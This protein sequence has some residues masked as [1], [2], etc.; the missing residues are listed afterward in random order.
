MAQ[1][2]LNAPAIYC[3]HLTQEISPSKTA[4]SDLPN[5]KQGTG[6]RPER[7]PFPGSRGDAEGS[8]VLLSDH[9]NAL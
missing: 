3:C 7:G 4:F 9:R 1:S 8:L 6:K 2:F 5:G